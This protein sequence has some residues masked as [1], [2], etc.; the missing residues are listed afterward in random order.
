LRQRF[1]GSAVIE[2]P[3]IEEIGRL[4]TGLRG[5]LAETEYLLVDGEADEL[6]TEVGWQIRSGVVFASSAK[7]FALCATSASRLV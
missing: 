6:L 4:A 2:Q 5:E 1:Q 3:G 7:R